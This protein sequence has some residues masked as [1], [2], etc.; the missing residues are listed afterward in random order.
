MKQKETIWTLPFI[1]I[2]AVNLALQMGQYMTN[3]LVP[4]YA[5]YLGGGAFLSWGW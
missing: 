5:A 2:F 1:S 3:L 4:K